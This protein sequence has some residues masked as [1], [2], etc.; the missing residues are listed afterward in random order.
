MHTPTTEW[1]TPVSCVHVCMYT[2]QCLHTCS[3]CVCVWGERYT[4]GERYWSVE[5]GWKRKCGQNHTLSLYIRLMCVHKG[6]TSSQGIQGIHL[7][8]IN[9]VDPLIFG[10]FVCLFVFCE[11]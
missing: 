3:L 9:Q 10:V 11:P 8:T 7:Q 1:V 6:Q 2:E 5:R 4:V